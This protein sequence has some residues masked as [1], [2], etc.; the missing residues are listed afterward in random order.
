MFLQ[1]LQCGSSERRKLWATKKSSLQLM[2]V[3]GTTG[4]SAD[5]ITPGT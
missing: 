2:V 3:V 4:L 5:V 1:C